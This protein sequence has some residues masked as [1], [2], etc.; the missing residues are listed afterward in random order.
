MYPIEEHHLDL[1]KETLSDFCQAIQI[2][3]QAQL[4]KIY[5]DLSHQIQ[6]KQN[7]FDDIMF[8]AQ[9]YG[10]IDDSL[11]ALMRNTTKTVKMKKKLTIAEEPPPIT[12]EKTEKESITVIAGIDDEEQRDTSKTKTIAKKTVANLKK[13]TEADETTTAKVLAS[14]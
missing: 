5:A 8:W 14:V 9:S 1:V 10:I 3:H 12:I 4:D 7:S 6:T 13:P 2:E 11:A